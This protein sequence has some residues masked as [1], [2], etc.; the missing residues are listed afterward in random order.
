[1]SAAIPISSRKRSR[2][3]PTATAGTPIA[4]V[5]RERLD[6]G[7]DGDIPRHW[8]GGDAF[9][10]RF[11]DAMSTMFPEGERFFINCVRDYR[12]QITDPQLRED[13]KNFI[14]QEGQHT[15]VHRQ[16][17]QR[18]KAQGID[19]DWLEGAN[20]FKLDR[21]RRV[22]PKRF[23][24]AM[25]AAAEHLTAVMSHG[26]FEERE[27]F[28]GSDPRLHAVY[29]WHGVE[30]IEHKGVAFDVMRKIAGVGYVERVTAMALLT[31]FF[32]HRVVLALNHMLEVDGYDA[33]QRAAAWLKGLWWLFGPAGLLAP[34][35]SHYLSY[36]QPGF[37]PWQ[38]G[39]MAEYQQWLQ[40]FDQTGDPVAAAQAA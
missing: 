31:I 4:I 3:R 11:F 36:Y 19:C 15:M 14:R 25:T 23:T 17:N 28:A 39:S 10:T 9:K 26:F 8:F 6:F 18:L 35:V 32:P 7:L 40:T 13:V 21:F 2:K 33:T 16:Y 12:G 34:M 30:E 20:G 27:A 24:L 37:H 5:P 1:M 22:L 29:L 38:H